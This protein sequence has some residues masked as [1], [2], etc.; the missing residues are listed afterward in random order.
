MSSAGISANEGQFSIRRKNKRQRKNLFSMSY[1]YSR[2]HKIRT[3]ERLKTCLAPTASNIIFR[4]IRHRKRF[5]VALQTEDHGVQFLRK[6]KCL[7]NHW[8]R[9]WIAV[10]IEAMCMVIKICVSVYKR[11]WQ[12]RG[13]PSIFRKTVVREHGQNVNRLDLAYLLAK[14]EV[15]N[16]LK[17]SERFERKHWLWKSFDCRHWQEL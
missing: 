16:A 4:L 3:C 12:S 13:A 6:T 10:K 17:K 7:V 8:I 14:V 5:I 9:V 15:W 11:L 1:S 2:L